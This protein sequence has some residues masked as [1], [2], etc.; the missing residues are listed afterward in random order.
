M[1]LVVLLVACAAWLAVPAGRSRSV[2]TLALPL[3]GPE[4]ALVAESEPRPRLWLWSGAAGIGAWAFV[5]GWPGLVAG[6]VAAVVVWVV[7]DRAETPA[8]RRR[9]ERTRADL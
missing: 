5:S 7:L 6:L 8:Q 2:A 9:R 4:P 3:V 1:T